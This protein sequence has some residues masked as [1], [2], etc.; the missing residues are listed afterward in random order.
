[1]LLRAARRRAEE[2]GRGWMA[3]FIETPP[4]DSPEEGERMRRLL[5]AARETGAEIAHVKAR[6]LHAGLMML[7]EKETARVTL[8]MLGGGDGTEP[9]NRRRAAPWMR[10]ARLA[11]RYAAVEVVPLSEP[12]QT[13]GLRVKLRP[14][15]RSGCPA[16][17]P[18]GLCPAGRGSGERCG[19][20]D[21]GAAAPQHLPH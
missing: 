17:A 7:L 4:D 2:T 8:V 18:A 16:L 15:P 3:A 9:L 5:E 12:P 14:G 6:S 19:L 11:E 21:G 1:M 10:A 20:V 13:G